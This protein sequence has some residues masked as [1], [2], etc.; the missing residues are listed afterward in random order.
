MGYLPWLEPTFLKQKFT[1]GTKRTKKKK[2]P[3]VPSFGLNEKK[4]ESP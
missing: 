1:Q 4:E 3:N 2:G